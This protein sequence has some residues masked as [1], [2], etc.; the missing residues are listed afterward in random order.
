MKK[1]LR[2]LVLLLP[3]ASALVPQASHAESTVYNATEGHVNSLVIFEQGGYARVYGLFTR[4]VGRMKFDE[5]GQVLDGLKLALLLKSFVSTSAAAQDEMNGHRPS[6]PNGEQEVAFVQTDTAR[7]QDNKA[8]VKGELLINGVRKDVI[9]TATLNKVGS[10][11]KSTDVFDEGTQTLGF[12]MHINFK[13]SDFSMQGDEKE[14][15]FKDSAVLM[16]DI[17]AQH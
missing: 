1:F 15:P 7:F 4:G 13:P 6:P 8:S 10:L 3:L 12:S 9:F 2:C 16:L 17:V 11:S 14:S 5:A